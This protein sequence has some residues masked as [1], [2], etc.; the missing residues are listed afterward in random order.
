MPDF[1]ADIRARLA[2]VR[3]TPTRELE[4]VDELAQHLGDRYDALVSG[5]ASP[6]EA[7]RRTRL[8]IPDGDALAARLRPLRQARSTPPLPPPRVGWSP[9]ALVVDLRHAARG[10]RRDWA[11]T[12]AV[13]LTLA[14]CVGA[15]TAVAMAVQTLLVRPLG[16]EGSS[17]V[18]NVWLSR[19]GRPNWHF[20]V[21][22]ADAQAIASGNH[23]FDGIGLYETQA[24]NL[25]GDGPPEEI[26]TAVVSAGFLRLLRVEG[27]IGRI[28]VDADESPGA[29]R[30]VLLGDG[31]WRR[32]FGAQPDVVGR[33]VRLDGVSYR[34][35]G[36]APRGFAVPG[37]SDAWIPRDRTDGGANAF[38]LARLRPGVSVERANA[39]MAVMVTA[40]TNGRP[41]PGMRFDVEPLQTTLT[42][43]SRASW[44][45][46]LGA[47][48]CVLGIGCVDVSVLMLARSLRR[49][50]DVDVRLALG[51]TRGQ[52]VRLFAAESLWLAGAGGAAALV[53]AWAGIHG[54]RALAPLDTPRLDELA[55]DPTALWLALATAA[56]A[57][58]AF[59]MLPALR[60][61]RGSAADALKASGAPAATS[62]A[63]AR[64]QGALV[65]GQMAL[66]VMLLAATALLG[67]SLLRLSE[68]DLGFDTD[69]LLTVRLN[70]PTGGDLA[71]TRRLATVAGALQQIR[72][73]PAVT[74]ASAATG[75]VLTGWGLPDATRTLA[76]RLVVEGGQAASGRPEEANLR[77]VDTG[78]FET[79]G[80]SVRHGRAFTA[81]DQTGG[82]LVA[83]VNRTMAR[84]LW[85]M[86]APLGRRFA[87]E[88]DGSGPRWLEVVG[89]VDDTR[90]IAPT[91][92]PAPTFFVPIGQ[93]AGG[94]ETDILHLYVRTSIDPLALGDA[95]R[96][97]VWRLD[98]AQPVEVSTMALAIAQFQ[99]APR[100]RIA[101]LGALAALGLLLAMLGTHAVVAHA[102]GQR[103]AEIAVRLALGAGRGSIVRSI[104]VRTLGLAAVAS[105]LGLVGAVTGAVVARGLLF[106]L[107]PVDAAS[108]TAATGMLVAVVLA[109]AYPIARRAGSVD[110]VQAL[111]SDGG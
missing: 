27:A 94:M 26:A 5:G 31:L 64:M 20:R 7:A 82:R 18:V 25:T 24:M 99:R 36:V 43:S 59:G 76:Q 40:I 91:A 22:A 71:A 77:R 61:S 67:R 69:R 107:A 97:L 72:G 65:V 73:L 2:G 6:E 68:V 12:T 4:I 29:A 81:A 95:V 75:P 70:A 51:A 13:V 44:L 100:F 21:P 55:V 33:D 60:G 106:E 8:E 19:S 83:I 39:D 89:V 47:V 86:D 35:V 9:A 41:N 79:L 11:F 1:R 104:V 32:R 78:Y 87:S 103:R 88:R 66:A 14:L 54:L 34:V 10:L 90:D 28:F 56:G 53:V 102:V 23:V 52:I 42:R 105:V 3:L 37:R 98:P 50:R 38:M 92:A 93:H 62:R 46:L 58:C 17:R 15:T 16:F 49:R 84:T 80:I 30:V 45:L 85:S 63:A 108:L 109:T 57:A 48:V 96:G 74:G 111:R 101:V 110:P